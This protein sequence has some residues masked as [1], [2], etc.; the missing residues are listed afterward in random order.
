MHPVKCRTSCVP[1]KNIPG[2]NLAFGSRK[3]NKPNHPPPSDTADN[4]SITHDKSNKRN[5]KNESNK[6]KQYNNANKQSQIR[7]VS[8]TPQNTNTLPDDNLILAIKKSSQHLPHVDDDCYEITSP[9]ISGKDDIAVSNYTS[10][11]AHSM[12]VLD[13][14]MSKLG[15]NPMNAIMHL[16]TGVA[17]SNS[18]SNNTKSA[19]D[20]KNAECESFAADILTIMTYRLDK[21]NNK[22]EGDKVDVESLT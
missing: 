17:T 10:I 18:C 14:V 9:N 5:K 22:Q 4:N 1:P 15:I 3:K 16:F 11:A 20:D 2:S 12:G 21:I 19:L 7:S 8:P 13:S 6:E